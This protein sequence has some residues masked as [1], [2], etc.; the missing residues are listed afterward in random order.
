MKEIVIGVYL[1]GAGLWL[2]LHAY[3][4]FRE[5][6][7]ANWRDDWARAARRTV[8][9]RPLRYYVAHVARGSLSAYLQRTSHGYCEFSLN[10]TQ[11]VHLAV[12]N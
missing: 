4:W 6:L 8:L 7:K 12:D 1:S 9:H 5:G 11:G 10:P 2:I 3:C